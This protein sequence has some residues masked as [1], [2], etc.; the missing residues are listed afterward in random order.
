MGRVCRFEWRISIGGALIT[1]TREKVLLELVERR[2]AAMTFA[3]ILFGYSII[4]VVSSYLCVVVM[5]FKSEQN[6]ALMSYFRFEF[7]IPISVTHI[8]L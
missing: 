5:R 8:I 4:F 1:C 3:L 2:D 7:F 6:Y